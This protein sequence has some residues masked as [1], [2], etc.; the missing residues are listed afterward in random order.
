MAIQYAKAMGFK[1][2]VV[3][4]DHAQ[5]DDAKRV[6]ADY[7]LKPSDLSPDHVVAFI[8]RTGGGVDAAVSFTTSSQSYSIMQGLIKSNGILVVAGII[9]ELRVGPIDVRFKSL[10][11]KGDSN[12]TTRDLKECLEFSA[13]HDIKASRK[14]IKPSDLPHAIEEM[15]SGVVRECMIVVF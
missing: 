2:V 4:N 15:K 11:I 14:F 1:V 8:K 13:K 10:F 9:D 7:T 12:V 3:E 6:G 5:L